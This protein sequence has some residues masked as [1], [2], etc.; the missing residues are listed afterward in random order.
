MMN[1]VRRMVSALTLLVVMTAGCSS[2]GSTSSDSGSSTK[3]S[4]R[5][6]ES[7]GSDAG[8]SGGAAGTS[9]GGAAVDSGARVVSDSGDGRLT[10]DALLVK[11]DM[12]CLQET[13]DIAQVSR[14][15]FKTYLEDGLKV[16]QAERDALGGLK[17]S[18]SDESRWK[19]YLAK[20]DDAI[21]KV[22]DAIKQPTELGQRNTFD[23]AGKRAD[24]ARQIATKL[25]FKECG[26]GATQI[27]VTTTTP[28][29]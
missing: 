14:E 19:D 15:K 27:S 29:K 20:L 2:G 28:R 8:K 11:G 26:T 7:A 4:G 16:L 5:S 22:R 25:G 9:S 13:Q 24:E 6:T 17:P 12:I 18:K 23:E 21:A 3:K 1:G 10:H